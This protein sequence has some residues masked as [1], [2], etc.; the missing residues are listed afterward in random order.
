MK[1][2][3]KNNTLIIEVPYS[4][5]GTPSKSGKSNNHYTTHGVK[6]VALGKQIVSVNLTV[7]SKA[8]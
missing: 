5:K 3:L 2:T 1:A 6:L 8:S 7:Y 4:Q